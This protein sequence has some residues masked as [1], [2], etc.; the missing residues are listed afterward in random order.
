MTFLWAERDHDSLWTRSS[1]SPVSRFHF[2]NSQKSCQASRRGSLHRASQH[3]R[4][5]VVK[6]KILWQLLHL[7]FG[8]RHEDGA[9]HR[10]LVQTL[11]GLP[12][13]SLTVRWRLVWASCPFPSLQNTG[14]WYYQ[15]RCTV[16][17]ARDLGRKFN[18]VLSWRYSCKVA[19][20]HN[21]KF[22]QHLH[23]VFLFCLWPSNIVT[24]SR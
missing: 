23:T 17:R 13:L 20:L 19:V 18:S 9:N 3:T 22:R 7:K 12:I 15:V 11:W 10:S 14:T 5:Y 21:W 8:S 6:G 4:L 1:R 24:T 2:F 16:H